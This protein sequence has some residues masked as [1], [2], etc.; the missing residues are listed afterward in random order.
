MLGVEASNEGI[1]ETLV[2]INVETREDES[3]HRGVAK[4]AF[5]YL[6][7]AEPL[8][9]LQALMRYGTT[10]DSVSKVNSSKLNKQSHLRCSASEGFCRLGRSGAIHP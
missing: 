7:A 1:S 4:I 2:P 3:V 10:Y 8:F 6:A 9:F 5:N